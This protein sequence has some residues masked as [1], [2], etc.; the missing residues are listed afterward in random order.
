M[1]MKSQEDL[2][3]IQEPKLEW[4]LGSDREREGDWNEGSV[5]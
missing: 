3:S 1:E 2:L 5:E 4:L